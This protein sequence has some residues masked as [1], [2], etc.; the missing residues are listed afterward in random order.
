MA[1]IRGEFPTWQ[2]AR[3]ATRAG[4]VPSDDEPPLDANAKARLRW[5]ALA[6]MRAEADHWKS[7]LRTGTMETRRRATDFFHRFQTDPTMA[8]VRNADA[9]DSLPADERNA[10]RAFWNDLAASLPIA[11]R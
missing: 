6:W 7:E 8:A 4:T 1:P 2:A 3:Y 11:P 10:W 5:Q 9:L